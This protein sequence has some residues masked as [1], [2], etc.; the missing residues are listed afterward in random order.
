[1]NDRDS[2]PDNV[3]RDCTGERPAAAPPMKVAV[4][5]YSGNV[6]KSIVAQHVLLPR[7][8][9]AELYSLS[10]GHRPG[11]GRRYSGR[12]CGAMLERLSTATSAV[13][14]IDADQA[15]E[16]IAT[17]KLYAGSHE[18]VDCFIVPTTPGLQQQHDTMQTLL[19]LTALGVQPHRI[20]L[21]FNEW[22]QVSTDPCSFDPIR[23]AIEGTF[24]QTEP[25]SRLEWIGV[26]SALESTDVDLEARA[27][28]L[29][30]RR[31]AWACVDEHADDFLDRTRKLLD[32][33]LAREA[34][35]R[36]DECFAALKLA[37]CRQ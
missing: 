11:K 26:F 23:D 12:Q 32:W 1:M 5:N 3:D 28:Q 29:S 36:L 30:A 14:D 34:V 9:G 20:K 6:G 10:S 4:V 27:E 35:H 16:Y 7:I 25:V 19:A 8:R 18:D 21:V 17:M 31:G 22:F 37:G 2:I 13:V 24:V 15:E 33:W